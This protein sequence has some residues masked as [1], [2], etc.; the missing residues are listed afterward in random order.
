MRKTGLFF[1]F[2]CADFDGNGFNDIVMIR[3]GGINQFTYNN[4][5]IFYNDG[6]G[7]FVEYPIGISEKY[8]ADRQQFLKCYPNP[9]Q[10]ETTLKFS[11]IETALVEISVCDIQG[12]FITC[13]INKKLKDGYHYISWN[14]I[15]SDGKLCK[16]GVYI[17]YLKVNGKICKPIKI[18][19]H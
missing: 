7:N 11:I 16:S 17:A 10:T 9:F 1:L 19:I 12:R 3:R 5:L 15:D 4:V 2:S 13:L 8:I 14:G 6:K 18:I